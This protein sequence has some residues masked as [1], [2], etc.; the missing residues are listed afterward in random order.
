MSA[1][2]AV[3]KPRTI[4]GV[5]IADNHPV[6]RDGLLRALKGRSDLRLVAEAE[7][8]SDA[9]ERVKELRPEIAVVDMRMPGLDGMQVLATVVR[10][11]PDTR[12]LILSAYLDG[13]VAYRA[14]ADGAAGFISKD[15]SREAICDAIATVAAG[16]IALCPEVE[17]GLASEIRKRGSEERRPE[18]TERETEILRMV[19]DGRTA[20]EIGEHLYLSPTTVKSHLRNLYRKLEVGDRAAA[21]AKAMRIGL[22][23]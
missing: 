1:P 23:D 5:L 11:F 3:G 12:V 4:A 8:G 19:A 10:E 15:S 17:S 13:E 14:L 9:L 2:A 21:V 7:D 22:I 16:G 6:Y 18:L 20:A